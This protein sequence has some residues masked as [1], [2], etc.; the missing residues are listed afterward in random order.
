MAFE[1]ICTLDDVWEGEMAEFTTGSGRDVLLVCIDGGRIKAFQAMC[2]HQEIALVEGTFEAGVITCRAHL[3]QFDSENG[4]GLNPTDCQIAEY[5]A[6]VDG[7]DIY[8]DVQGIEP[9]KSH[10]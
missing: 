2:P 8:V 7:Q 5:P 4:R 1:K 6:R 10:S 9:C 3:W